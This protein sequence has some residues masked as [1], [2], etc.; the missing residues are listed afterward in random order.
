MTALTNHSGWTLSFPR[1]WVAPRAPIASIPEADGG[2]CE[3]MTRDRDGTQAFWAPPTAPGFPP[4]YAASMDRTTGV[5][6]PPFPFPGEC[7]IMPTTV[8]RGRIMP[9][10]MGIAQGSMFVR[11]GR[12]LHRSR[13]LGSLQR[14][15]DGLTRLRPCTGEKG[16]HCGANAIGAA[17]GCHVTSA[18]ANR[19]NR[20]RHGGMH[21]FA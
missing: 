18:I 8:T 3:W 9:R 12:A 19:Q 14:E 4:R 20:L 21:R 16:T 1:T 5:G 7:K 17:H 11:Q 2:C 6:P 13:Q 15:R 10:I